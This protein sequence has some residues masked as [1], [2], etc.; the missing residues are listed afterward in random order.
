MCQT[1]LCPLHGFER[2][3]RRPRALQDARPQQ[4]DPTG[5]PV[6]AVTQLVERDVE[7]CKG[8]LRLAEE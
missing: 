4:E 1:T 2:L 3:R 6:V 5:E 8:S 7:R